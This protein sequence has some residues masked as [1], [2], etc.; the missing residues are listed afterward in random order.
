M[1]HFVICA[2]NIDKIP[3]V[4][5]P[6]LIV[7]VSMLLEALKNWHKNLPPLL[8]YVFKFHSCR[9]DL[10]FESLYSQYM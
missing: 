7:H 2:Q 5:C 9:V 3:L 4:S 8:L 1:P 6:V 10:F